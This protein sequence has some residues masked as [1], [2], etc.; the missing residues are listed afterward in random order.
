MAETITYRV[1]ISPR[2]NQTTATSK[3]GEYDQPVILSTTNFNAVSLLFNKI[4]AGVDVSS[5][6]TA[7]NALP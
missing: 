5:V 1:S 2:L 7:I 6:V 3:E 4:V